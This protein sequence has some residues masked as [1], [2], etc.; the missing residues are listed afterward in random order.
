MLRKFTNQLAK[1]DYLNGRQNLARY[2]RFLRDLDARSLQDET[3][4]K[5]SCPGQAARRD[6]LLHHIEWAEKVM[7]NAIAKNDSDPHEKA[8]DQNTMDGTA[9]A[10]ACLNAKQNYNRYRRFLAEFDAGVR[11]LPFGTP[12]YATEKNERD[13]LVFMLKRHGKAY[14]D[15][16]LARDRYITSTKSLLPGPGG[17]TSRPGLEFDHETASLPQSKKRK[18]MSLWENHFTA[19]A[20]ARKADLLQEINTTKPIFTTVYGTMN[21][22]RFLSTARRLYEGVGGNIINNILYIEV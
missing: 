19:T 17:G 13:R 21:G 16:L 6:N 9:H 3:S 1:R 10:R 11:R 18:L 4:G 12:G 2:R 22:S 5:P 7:E 8:P 20:T 14:N 15:A